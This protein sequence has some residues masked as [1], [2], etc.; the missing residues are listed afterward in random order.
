MSARNGGRGRFQA[1]CHAVHFSDKE[2]GR[3]PF[4][5]LAGIAELDFKFP[6]TSLREF[7]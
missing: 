1:A 5:R 4:V 3:N 2:L 7:V 6:V